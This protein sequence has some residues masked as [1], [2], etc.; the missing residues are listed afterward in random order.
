MIFS[1]ET[2]CVELGVPREWLRRCVELGLVQVARQG[3][4]TGFDSGQLRRIWS[5]WSLQEDLEVNPAGASI[6]LEMSERIRELR[7]ALQA[8][9]HRVAQLERLE[10]FQRRLVEEEQG[11]VEWEIDL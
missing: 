4:E 8:A 7:Q 6:I 2:V 9:S 11:A 3:R 5:L 1:E 10:Q